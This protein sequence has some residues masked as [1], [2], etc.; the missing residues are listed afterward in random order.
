[1]GIPSRKRWEIINEIWGA[2]QN[3]PLPTIK[4][5]VSRFLI[6]SR[7]ETEIGQVLES[8]RLRGCYKKWYKSKEEYG[9]REINSVRLNEVHAEVH[10]TYDSEIQD[11]EAKFYVTKQGDGFNYLGRYIQPNN[12]AYYL[13]FRALFNKLPRGGVIPYGELDK[14]IRQDIK[15]TKKFSSKEMRA[16]MHRNLI[17]ESNS[18]MSYFKIEPLQDNGLRL[19]ETVRKFGIKFNNKTT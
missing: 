3:A 17:D 18:F 10:S 1:M 11:K 7:T 6:R 19:T 15:K 8:F 14:A 9:F 12:R 4:I 2:H 16:F 5:P 13:S